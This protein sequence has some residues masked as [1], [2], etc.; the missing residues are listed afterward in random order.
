MPRNPEHRERL[1]SW[2]NGAPR[3]Y[4]IPPRTA[5][6]AVRDLNGTDPAPFDDERLTLAAMGLP[7]LADDDDL[8]ATR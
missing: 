6:A 4:H 1:S 2:A 7:P 8:E 3:V 5:L